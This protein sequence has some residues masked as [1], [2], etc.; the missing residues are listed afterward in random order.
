MYSKN[1][2]MM[3]DGKLHLLHIC[4]D[5]PPAALMDLNFQKSMPK[6]VASLILHIGQ[7]CH[8]FHSAENKKDVE[9]ALALWR[10][11]QKY[12]TPAM[13]LSSQEQAQ[14][15]TIGHASG[16]VSR[17]QTKLCAGVE[18]LC[19]TAVK[20]LGIAK[21]VDSITQALALPQPTPEKASQMVHSLRVA[22]KLGDEL[23]EK[24]I[25]PEQESLQSSLSVYLKVHSMKLDFLRAV[26][27]ETTERIQRFTM[28]FEHSL[29]TWL[30]QQT[31][32]FRK[33]LEELE[34]YRPVHCS[35][36]KSF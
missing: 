24:S 15:Q 18:D 20:D 35:Q 13:R 28:T 33:P 12:L 4:C 34:Q 31:E 22:A 2:W 29:Q 14:H 11:V 25:L 3:T 26:V 27:P 32:Y 19:K 5:A 9:K 17:L 10:V 23:N 8:D 16:M 21:A 30:E 7:S 6:D 1:T 36:T